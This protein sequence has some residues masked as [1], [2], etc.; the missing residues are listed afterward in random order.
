[1]NFP[2]LE[3][4][5]L[6]T[7]NVN[8]NTDFD[9]F[10]QAIT[11]TAFYVAFGIP[12][13]LIILSRFAKNINLGK[14]PWYL[15]SVV[16]SSAILSNILKYIINR[17]RP[18]ITYDII[19]KISAGGSPSFPSGHTSDAFAI[20]TALTI[21]YPKWYIIIPLYSWA[22]LVAYSRLFVGVHY[23]SDVIAGATIGIGLAIIGK[24]LLK[25][26]FLD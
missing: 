14:K 1:M 11:H 15:F 23:L 6:K 2:D 12:V 4:E 10:F 22:F 13:L 16:I 7:I 17:P 8:R 24:V 25:R 19:E 5:I 9:V 21:A 26:R 20:A 18:F 3:L